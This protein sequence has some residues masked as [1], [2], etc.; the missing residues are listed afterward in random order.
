MNKEETTEEAIIAPPWLWQ[1]I[2]RALHD[3]REAKEIYQT[4][5]YDKIIIMS[6]LEQAEA[7]LTQIKTMIEEYDVALYMKTAIAIEILEIA[8]QEKTAPER[9]ITNILKQYIQNFKTQKQK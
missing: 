8:E 9:L 5:P 4:N 6:K 1:R 3:V 7:E 2:K